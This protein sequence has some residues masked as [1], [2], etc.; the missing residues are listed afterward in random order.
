M[1]ALKKI[2][3]GTDAIIA[4]SV[5]ISGNPVT[6]SEGDIRHVY[7]FSDV[8]GQP[9][10]E[11]AHKAEGQTLRC[12]YAAKDQNYT[13]PFR[14]IVEFADGKA[15]SSSLDVPAFEIVR[16]TE[17]ADADTG[18]VVLDIDGTMRFYSLSEAIAKIEA[19]T[20]AATDAAAAA[21]RSAGNADAKATAAYEA[22]V[23]A[24]AAAKAAGATNTSVAEAEEQRVNAENARK[25]AEQARADAE[26]ARA[27]AEDKRTETEAKRAEAEAQRAAG[28]QSR[29]N[30]ETGRVNA[31]SARV[32]A[33]SA[34][35][36]AEA[37]RAANEE[38]RKKNES[39]RTS[40]EAG[41][42]EAEKGRVTEE[43]T[44]V[45]EFAR[46]KKESETATKNATD[47]A[48]EA[49]EVSSGV[50]AL[51]RDLGQY[52]ELPSVAMTAETTG[53]YINAEGEFVDDADFNIAAIGA[54]VVG[55]TYEL[56]MGSADKMKLGV[57]LL[58]ARIKTTTTSGT[59][60]IEYVPLFSAMST[61]IPTSGYVCFEAMEAYSDVLV[62]YR[63]DVPEAAT[64]LVRRYGTKASIA[65]QI[66]NLR[67]KVDLKSFADGYYESMR[68]GSA[69]NLTSKGDATETVIMSRRAG[70]DNQIE[71]GSA[72]IKRIKGYSVVKNQLYNDSKPP[73][74][75]SARIENVGT[76]KYKCTPK[77]EPNNAGSA[78]WASG[79]VMISETLPIGH[80]FYYR[81]LYTRLSKREDVGEFEPS[82]S[83]V[84]LDE[85]TYN[86]FSPELGKE[87]IVC[88]VVKGTFGKC[89]VSLNDCVVTIEN[90][91]LIDLT[92]MFGSGNEPSTPDDF[93]KRLGYSSIN[94]VPYIPYNEGEI[95]SSFAEGIKT[96]DTEG[97]VSERKW[98]ETLKKYF[99]DGLKSAGSAYDEITPTKAVKRIGAVNLGDLAWVQGGENNR[100]SWVP[101][102]L[103]LKGTAV[104]PTT[105]YEVSN[106]KS[107]KYITNNSHIVENQLQDKEIC[108]NRNGWIY[109]YDS[110]YETATPE[111]FK[112]SLQGVML[113]YEM[114][115]PEETAYDELNL[116]EQVSAG[117]TEEAIITDGKTSTP[118]RADIVYPIDAYNTI[119]ANKT[120]IGTLSSLN[121]ASK[122]DLVSAINELAGKVTALE[123]KAT[124]VTNVTTE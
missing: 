84:I 67:N 121:T 79:W 119:K 1:T 14:V 63:A 26:T 33:E 107:N 28:E 68:V 25:E 43:S 91:Q 115:T 8:Q 48:A 122:T 71:D 74:S 12:T 88:N 18:E 64:L 21:Y 65:T 38:Q 120:N 55:N 52:A 72:S 100:T 78:Q 102:S 109:I 76:H 114:A 90:I 94:D 42:V 5:N 66:N 9:V 59:E 101:D 85:Y 6:W 117:G 10:A 80:I 82:R 44:R 73:Y 95:V 86:Y 60:R 75:G 41:R 40:A 123:A 113:Y 108:L 98:S 27:S 58:V 106:I 19:A 112:Q 30:A 53:K 51:E 111:Q 92:Q 70:G 3:I 103:N 97:K 99:P 11:M 87:T 45:A 116:T 15:F 32:T 124:E 77:I 81:M 36:N 93:A 47:A 61:D 31:E 13:G 2:R 96:T 83:A 57:A 20:K 49:K 7:A 69:D 4:L 62:C 105:I 22:A 23:K 54:V 110:A 104:L 118:L 24:N 37:T 56:Y 46:L 29:V 16:T 35:S 50:A 89:A 34:R 39:E 17:E